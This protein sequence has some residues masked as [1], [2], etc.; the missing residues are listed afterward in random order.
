MGRALAFLQPAR[1]KEE[2]APGHTSSTLFPETHPQPGL[3]VPSSLPAMTTA[4]RGPGSERGVCA[5]ARE[6][7][8]RPALLPPVPR[9]TQ[10]QVVFNI[11]GCRCPDPLPPPR[12]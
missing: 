11:L 8:V 6:G 12:W 10:T 9:C 5:P 3:L 1:Q 7:S 4:T 2:S